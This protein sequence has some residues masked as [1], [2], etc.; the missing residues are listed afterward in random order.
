MSDKEEKAANDSVTE[1]AKFN[2]G[3]KKGDAK[4][5]GMGETTMRYAT[6]RQ[7]V[8]SAEIP[9]LSEGSGL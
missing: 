7:A 8:D 2:G 9:S 4:D 1:V 6:R 3:P 5:S